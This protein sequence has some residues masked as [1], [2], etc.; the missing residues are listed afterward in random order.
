MVKMLKMPFKDNFVGLNYSI[1]SLKSKNVFLLHRMLK[2][3]SE[4]IIKNN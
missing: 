1:F 3:I 2:M 4:E